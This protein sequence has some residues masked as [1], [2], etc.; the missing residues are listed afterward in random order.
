MCYICPLYVLMC[1]YMCLYRKNRSI[2]TV[3][4]PLIC[5]IYVPYMCVYVLICAYTERVNWP[6]KA[7]R[8]KSCHPIVGL[9]CLL[10]VLVFCNFFFEFMS[11]FGLTCAVFA[12]CFFLIFSALGAI[13]NGAT[14]CFLL[15]IN[16]ATVK[17]CANDLFT[18][19][20]SNLPELIFLTFSTSCA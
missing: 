4:S 9:F 8:L 6:L 15:A 11:V 12:G 17:F 2:S 3:N 7:C 10:G 14:V 16:W 1:A 18:A 5:A 20:F 19:V 13:T